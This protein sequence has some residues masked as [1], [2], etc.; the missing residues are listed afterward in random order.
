MNDLLLKVIKDLENSALKDIIYLSFKVS[1]FRLIYY[2]PYLVEFPS[3][4]SHLYSKEGILFKNIFRLVFF[5]SSFGIYYFSI[6]AL[7]AFRFK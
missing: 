5:I 4:L 3:Q 7:S 2:I 1:I 6:F